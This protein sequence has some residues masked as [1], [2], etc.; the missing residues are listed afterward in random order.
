MW[1]LEFIRLTYLLGYRVRSR[2]YKNKILEITSIFVYKLFSQ[3]FYNVCVY[4]PP[5]CPTFKKLG[6]N[7]LTPRS[8]FYGT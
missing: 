4:T 3:I 6:N 2:Y 8:N 7:D 5:L 1:V